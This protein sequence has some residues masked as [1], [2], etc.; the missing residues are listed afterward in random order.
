[1][2]SAI[3]EHENAHPE[4]FFESDHPEALAFDR[5]RRLLNSVMESAG[6][7]RLPHEWWHFSY[8]DQRA[9]FENV[10]RGFMNLDDAAAAYG[11]ADLIGGGG[12]GV[13]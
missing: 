2:G 9:V 10:R 6:F 13:R 8:R 4:A 12:E 11:R 1:M 5:N 3:D 7:V